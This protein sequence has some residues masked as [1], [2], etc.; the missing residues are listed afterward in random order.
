VKVARPVRG[1]AARKRPTRA[2]RRAADSTPTLRKQLKSLPWRQI[3]TLHRDLSKGHGR[4]EK[5]GIQVTEVAAGIAF[6]GAVSALRITRGVTERRKGK[7]RRYTETVYAVTSLS[8]A[9]ATPEQIAGWLRGHWKIESQLHWVR[10][11]TFGEDL[12][13]IRT[14]SGPQT[15]A[16]LRNLVVS[17]LRLDG[18]TNI[19]ATL[20]YYG[21]DFQRP[22]DMLLAS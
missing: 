11:V 17:L 22:I 8:V 15:M 12:S 4:T 2:P 18:H 19:A 6:P 9:E 20:R 10:D 5:R 1:A 21:R 13:Q 7:V 16:T 3:P 14:G